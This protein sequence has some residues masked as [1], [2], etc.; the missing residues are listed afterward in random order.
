MKK[1]KT[2]IIFALLLYALPFTLYPS[3]THAQTSD[4]EATSVY[5]IADADAQEGDIVVTTDK[6]L[7]RAS[8]SFD[9]KMLGVITETPV[10]VFRSNDEKGKPVIRSGTA[11]VNVTTLNG[12]IKYGDYITSSTISGKGQKAFESGYVIGVAL[13]EFT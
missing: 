5:E 1:L 4:I 3:P 13:A 6:G 11:N 7:V 9:N 10:L 2:Q 12:P 8:K